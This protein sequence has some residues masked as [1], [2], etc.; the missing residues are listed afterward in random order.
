MMMDD[1]NHADASS[2]LAGLQTNGFCE[3]SFCITCWSTYLTYVLLL[4]NWRQS[5]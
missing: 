1:D 2:T 5:D 4:I 3:L